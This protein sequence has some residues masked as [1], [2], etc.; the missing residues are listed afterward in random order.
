ME[1]IDRRDLFDGFVSKFVG[2]TVAQ[3]GLDSRTGE[4][5]GKSRRVVI[6]AVGSS[7]E[8][9]HAAEFGAPDDQGLLEESSLLEVT[10]ESGG[11]LIEDF[12]VVCVLVFE[13]FVAVPIACSFSSDLVGSVEQ[14]HESDPLF[15]EFACQD[16]VFGVGCFGF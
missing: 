5:S 2:S 6:A 1:V 8:C 10:Q 4:P 15:D 11:G 12:S 3:G 7:L 13:Y 16:A 14:L 9:R